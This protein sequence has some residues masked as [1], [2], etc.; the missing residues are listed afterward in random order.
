MTEA[1]VERIGFVM[2]PEKKSTASGPYWPYGVEAVA[3]G[4]G[5]VLKPRTKPR[6]G[7]EKAF[8][9]GSKAKDEL[10]AVRQLTNKFDDSD[11]KW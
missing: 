9:K 10:S 6:A 8:K 5:L 1:L 2:K 4:D 7:W 11:W 3:S